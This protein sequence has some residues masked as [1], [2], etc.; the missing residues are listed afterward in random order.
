M[1]AREDE[2]IIIYIAVK[3]EFYWALSSGLNVNQ[4]YDVQVVTHLTF[5]LPRRLFAP[6]REDG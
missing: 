2:G 1:R 6:I 4:P 3:P 5:H